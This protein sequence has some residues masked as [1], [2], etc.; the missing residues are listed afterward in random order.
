MKKRIIGI[1]MVL[2]LMVFLTG[3]E[4]EPSNN[5]AQ[6]ETRAVQSSMQEMQR[7]VGQPLIDDF[8]EKKMAKLIYELRDNAELSTYAYMVNLDGKYVF[9]GRCIGFGLP[10]SV[11]YTSP[12]KMVNR[13]GENIG[14]NGNLGYDPYIMPQAD[15]N[16]LYMPE[17]LSATWLMLVNEQTGEPEIIY[18]EPSIIVTQS[19]LPRRLVA[20]W[21]ISDDY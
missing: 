1:I 17:G 12:S 7:E 15:P 13:Y 19:K 21:S 8:Y 14:L 2:F 16:G 18:T 11:Q 6:Q 5:V 20:N 4:Y 3:C 10:Y 9:L